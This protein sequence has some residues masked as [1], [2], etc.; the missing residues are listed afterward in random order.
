M[1][2]YPETARSVIV[3]LQRHL[4]SHFVV[5]ILC[6]CVW[7]SKVNHRSSKVVVVAKEAVEGSEASILSSLKFQ[8][9]PVVQCSSYCMSN[10]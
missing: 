2:L 5:R 7:L 4:F 3:L 1:Y 10:C 9:R 6:V 8:R